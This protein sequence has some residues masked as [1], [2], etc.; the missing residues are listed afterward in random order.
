[1]ANSM[2]SCRQEES[3]MPFNHDEKAVL[4]QIARLLVSEKLM[5]PEEQL[6]FLAILKEEA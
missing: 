3:Y 6:R 4:G 2:D 1:M 5:E